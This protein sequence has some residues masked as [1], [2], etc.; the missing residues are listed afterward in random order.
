[1]DQKSPVLCFSRPGFFLMAQAVIKL[2]I[3]RTTM[4]IPDI[5]RNFTMGTFL[6]E[7][8][9]SLAGVRRHTICESAWHFPGAR[10]MLFHI[11]E[12][13]PKCVVSA[14]HVGR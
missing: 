7:R 4:I 9:H 13:L 5:T 8:F 3:S 10:H 11:E 12:Q 1:M 6:S 2:L 14:E